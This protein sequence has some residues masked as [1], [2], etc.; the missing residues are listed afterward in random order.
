MPEITYPLVLTVN[1][2]TANLAITDDAEDWTYTLGEPTKTQTFAFS[3]TPDCYPET[4]TLTPNLP[5]LTVDNNAGTIT[6]PQTYDAGI[7]G[8]HTVSIQATID[9][10]D[11]FT[12]ATTTTKSQTITFTITVIDPAPVNVCPKETAWFYV[13]D[14]SGGTN[15]AAING[16]GYATPDL[17]TAQ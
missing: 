5:W 1:P 6:M 12:K 7:A 2:C 14:T 16:D 11:D 9:E 3:Q 13:T 17:D 10:W 4:I 8:T 15:Y